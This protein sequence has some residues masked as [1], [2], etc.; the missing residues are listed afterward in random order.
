MILR[1]LLVAVLILL[2]AAWLTRAPRL[3]RAIWIVMVA[4]A[5]YGVLKAT[6]VIEAIAPARDG[7]I[8]LDVPSGHKMAI[9][10]PVDLGGRVKGLQ[11]NRATKANV[12]PIVRANL[13]A[14]ARVI[15][16]DSSL[17]R[18]MDAEYTH[19]LVRHTN[20]AGELNPTQADDRFARLMDDIGKA[21]APD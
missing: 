15:T 16:D 11:V 1:L 18:E 2:V 19:A 7:A 10:S 17:Y 3:R 9:L 21:R 4:I 14:E 6:G 12:L 5:V 20:G 8:V 13:D